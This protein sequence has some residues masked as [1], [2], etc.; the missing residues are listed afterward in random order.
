MLYKRFH[1]Q[2]H[3]YHPT[4]TFSA[5]AVDFVD[6]FVSGILSVCF[7]PLFFPVHVAVFYFYI[8]LDLF[9]SMYL[10]NA[11]I[12]Y[13][14]S[15]DGWVNTNV[16]HTVHHSTSRY[17]YGMFTLTWDRLMGTYKP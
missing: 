4:T 15:C 16:T 5:S 9:W 3:V 14:P 11:H 17:N 7:N 1:A 6:I 10:H 13:V 8:F 2:H 12:P